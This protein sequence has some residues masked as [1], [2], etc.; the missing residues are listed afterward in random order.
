MLILVRFPKRRLAIGRC[1]VCEIYVQRL[2]VFSEVASDPRKKFF[3]KLGHE[4]RDFVV[5]FGHSLPRS[6]DKFH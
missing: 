4:C 3:P 1:S 5:T 2:T 6:G